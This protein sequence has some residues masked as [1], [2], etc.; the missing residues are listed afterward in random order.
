MCYFFPTKCSSLVLVAHVFGLIMYILLCTNILLNNS[1]VVATHEHGT[2]CI[3]FCIENI[4]CLSLRLCYI[5]LLL[6]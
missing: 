1:C 3:C 2:L 5:F 4:F 6:L